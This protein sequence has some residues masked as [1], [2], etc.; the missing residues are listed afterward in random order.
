MKKVQELQL[1]RAEL[2]PAEVI[3]DSLPPSNAYFSGFTSDSLAPPVVKESSPLFSE[4]SWSPVTPPCLG[5]IEI[6]WDAGAISGLRSLL[7]D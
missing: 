6:D 2:P 5:M 7:L 3:C 1:S 4:F